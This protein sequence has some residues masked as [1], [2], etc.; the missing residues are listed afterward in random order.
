MTQACLVSFSFPCFWSL[1]IIRGSQTVFFSH[2][3]VSYTEVEILRHQFNSY[4]IERTGM[5]PIKC[6]GGNYC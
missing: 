4:D 2:S 5:I 3:I 6:V 1:L